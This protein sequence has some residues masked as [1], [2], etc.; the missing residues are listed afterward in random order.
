MV[1]GAS[2]VRLKYEAKLQIHSIVL[3]GDLNPAIF[4]PAW[5]AAEDLINS[6]EAKAAN[7]EIVSAQATLFKVDWLNV[8]VLPQRFVASTTNEAY[9]RPLCDFVLSTFSKLIHTPIRIMGLNYS[10]H[11]RL[12]DSEQWHFVGHELA[13][14]DRWRGLLNNPGL[15]SLTV[16]GERQDGYV[17]IKLEPSARIENGIFVETNNHYKVTSDEPGCRHMLDILSSEWHNT[18][19]ESKD[20][21]GRM[22][23]NE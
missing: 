1:G 7:V 19:G 22:F 17:R 5:F 8:Q 16:Q 18:F 20:V 15:A 21:L 6:T 23:P 10:Y 12:E 3:I 13:P 9:Y 11:Y 4:Q 2:S 14:K